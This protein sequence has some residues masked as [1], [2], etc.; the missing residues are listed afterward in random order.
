LKKPATVRKP[1]SQRKRPVDEAVAYAVGNGTRIDALAILAEGKHSP[2]EIA[3]ILGVDTRLVGNHIREL[4]ACGCIESAGTTKVRN[5]TQH[6]Y[7]A[8]ATPFVS[9]EAY[10]AMPIAARREVISVL[11]QAIVTEALASLRAGKMEA[12]DDVCLIWDCVKLDQQ[13]RRELSVEMQA[14]YDRAL[15]LEAESESRLAESGE[16][17]VMTFV[18]LM[19]CERSRSG[20]PEKRYP[21]PPEDL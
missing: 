7:K 15:E 11:V 9:D 8:L 20:R 5:V 16:K 6:F 14:Q 12:D 21:Y 1:I 10:R 3:E 18:S 13:A 17:E 4:F 19:A 2:S